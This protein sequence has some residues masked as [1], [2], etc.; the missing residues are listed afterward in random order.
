MGEAAVV[1]APIWARNHLESARIQWNAECD[2]VVFISL[3][4]ISCWN[5]EQFVGIWRHGCVNFC[6]AHDD[7]VVSAI[8]NADVV[9]RM[10]LLCRPAAAVTLHV[11]LSYSHGQVVVAAVFENGADAAADIVVP[12]FSSICFATRCSAKRQSVPI[13]LINTTSVLPRRVEVSINSASLQ[14][15]IGSDGDFEI[16]AVLLAI[17]RIPINGEITIRGVVG[18]FIVDGGMIYRNPIDRMGR[19]VFD[20][21]TFEIHLAPIVQALLILFRGSHPSTPSL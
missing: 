19:Y 18:D 21:L 11:G 4:Q 10:Y 12:N 13:S 15:I 1:A 6:A 20:T 14:K 3:R 17:L 16:P 2:R 7:A 9:V 5:D 8:H